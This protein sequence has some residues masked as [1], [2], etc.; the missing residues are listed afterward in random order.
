MAMVG[1]FWIAEGDVYVGAKPSG[2][3]PGVRLTPEGV[4]AL[5]DRQSGVHLWED[6]SALT[7]TDVP[8]KSL[9]RQA[10]VIKNLAVTMVVNLAI[11]MVP[12]RADEAPPLMTLH[13]TSPGAEHE[14]SVY[15]AAAV[16]YSPTEIELS[17]ALLARLTEGAATMTT[18][19]TA[20]SEWGRTSEGETPR[21]A[22]RERLLRSWAA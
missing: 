5:G 3:A 1:L 10:G 17:R 7:M 18:T 12:D 9:V 20:M 8:V 4:V 6:V 2:L 16:G 15:A 13:V 14:L 11:P 22:E 21:G 19:L